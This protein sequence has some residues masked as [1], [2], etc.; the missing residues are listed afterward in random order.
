MLKFEKK[1][2]RQK[3][4]EHILYKCFVQAD[5]PV[6]QTDLDFDM[7]GNNETY[8]DLNIHLYGPR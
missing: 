4:K 7:P 2:R 6:G 3:V 5:R 8:I 1:I